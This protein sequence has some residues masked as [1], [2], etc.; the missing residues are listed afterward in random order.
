MN[1]SRSVVPTCI[2]LALLNQL[3][4]ARANDSLA[5]LEPSGLNFSKTD[6]IRMESEVLS[7]S[8]KETRVVYRFVN[9]SKKEVSAI[10][11]FPLPRMSTETPLE[12]SLTA[13]K[14]PYLPLANPFDFK[15][16]ANGISVTPSL[17]L[18]HFYFVGDP[19]AKKQSVTTVEKV[20]GNTEVGSTPG[21]ASELVYKYYWKQ[22]FPP[23]QT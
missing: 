19:T 7:I 2:I 21:D 5:T 15:I 17:E 12:I 20:I 9:T 3:P 16:K 6:S 22:K 8:L 13:H 10:V 11:E 1:R 4:L 23:G 18:T 14:D